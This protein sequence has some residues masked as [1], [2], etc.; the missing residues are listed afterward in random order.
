[1]AKSLGLTHYL[2]YVHRILLGLFADCF[3]DKQLLV[4]DPKALHHVIVKVSNAGTCQFFCSPRSQ[5]QHIYE[6]TSAFILYIFNSLRACYAMIKLRIS[7][8]GIG[9]CLVKD[10]WLH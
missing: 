6:E 10:F 2:V 9:L 8:G 7:T 5:D 1:M 3:Q 4:H